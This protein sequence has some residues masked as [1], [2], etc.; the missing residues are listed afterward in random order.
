MEQN[1]CILIPLTGMEWNGQAVRF[2]DGREAVE[3]IL[4]APETVRGA[5]CYYFKSDLR[6][7]F[8]DEGK[9]EFIECLG[10]IDG[11]F[12]PEIYG[13]SAFQV[14]AEELLELLKQHN[15]GPVDDG[16]AGYAYS[17]L[18]SSV[19]IY[20]EVTP[21]DMDSML[22]EISKI[23]LTKMGNINIEEEKKKAYHWATIGIGIQGY[24]A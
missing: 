2:G 19:G 10:G 8:D 16:E 14:E 17:F 9:L 22:L 1:T 23:D 20:R 11:S 6:F 7:D 4:G 18:N 13:V 21:E 15:D 24:Y 12:Q 3:Q 5:H